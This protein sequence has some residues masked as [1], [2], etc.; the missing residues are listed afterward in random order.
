MH[1]TLRFSLVLVFFS[2][3]S[4][5]ALS[6]TT[7]PLTSKEVVNLLYQ[8]QRQPETR[9]DVIDEIRKRGID[10]PLTAGMRSLVATK[11]GNDSLLRRTLEEAERRRLNP[12]ASAL[13][14]ET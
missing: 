1:F 11:S 9:D 4:V 3:V 2:V 6:Q 14:S 8:L 13:P 7:K 10:F 5:A 12:T